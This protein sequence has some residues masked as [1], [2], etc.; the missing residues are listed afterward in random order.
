MIAY[1]LEAQGII[2]PVTAALHQLLEGGTTSII[3]LFSNLCPQLNY[4][5]GRINIKETLHQIGGNYLRPY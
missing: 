1:N 5:F 3:C 2:N 4:K